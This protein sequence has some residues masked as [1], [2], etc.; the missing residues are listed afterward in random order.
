MQIMTQKKS[1]NVAKLSQKT[2]LEYIEK[3][4]IFQTLDEIA[5]N[6]GVNPRT[7]DRDIKKWK[8]KGGFTRFLEKEFF[9]LYGIEKRQNPSGA[10]NR[11]MYLMGKQ[12]QQPPTYNQINI[13]K[14]TNELIQISREPECKPTAESPC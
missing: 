5:Q 6:C 14:L 9:E 7:I 2:R 4:I 8:A 10:L 11:I 3:N 1:L 12:L 13:N